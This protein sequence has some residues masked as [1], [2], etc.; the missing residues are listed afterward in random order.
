MRVLHI[1][2]GNLYGGVETVLVNLARF[3]HFCPALEPEFALCFEGR[4]SQELRE[5]GVA[6]H[7]LG[8][9]RT[10]KP[11]TVWS[12]RARLRGLLAEKPFDV[13]VCHMAWPMAIFG[14][15]VRDTGLPVA[16]WAHEVATGKHWLE[17]WA[18]RVSPDMVIANS[19]F[20]ATSVRLLF[21]DAPCRIVHCPVLP[22]QPADA[23]SCRA[24]IRRTLGVSDNTVAIVQVSR[25]EA[26]KGHH[27][28][29]DA[30]AEL[31][32]DPRWICWVVGGA[33]R[34]MEQEYMRQ[35]QEQAARLGIGDR[36]RFLGQR[37]DVSSLLAA[38]D[39]FSQPN[40]GAESF[41]IVFI[42]ALAAGLPVVTTALGGP[43]EIV[44]ESCGFLVPPGD[45]HLLAPCLGRLID[46]PDLRSRLGQRGPQRARELCDPRGRIPEL[47]EALSGV[48]H[49]ETM[50]SAVS[51]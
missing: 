14:N 5:T 47:Y 46:S 15:T 45:A 30:L 36:V 18:R 35:V 6:V 37:S 29:L 8:E 11:W 4:I 7:Q 3:R 32:D 42:E 20:T 43:R 48:V 24:E 12:A 40:A 34:P 50:L 25:M 23:A 49:P 26:G 41:G 33:Q 21:P 38:A 19:R 1:T 2:A 31:K 51:S 39:I 10:R 22:S 17:R 28:H 27:L 16:F 9:V 44:D 13:A